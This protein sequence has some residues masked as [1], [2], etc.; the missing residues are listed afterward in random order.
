MLRRLCG[1]VLSPSGFPI[2]SPRICSI[3]TYFPLFSD[4]VPNYTGTHGWVDICMCACVYMSVRTHVCLCVC[5][6]ACWPDIVVTI[7]ASV[8][9]SDAE[10]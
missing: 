8:L 1:S 4:I 7:A 9:D 2:L 5:V 10:R 6:C 3:L